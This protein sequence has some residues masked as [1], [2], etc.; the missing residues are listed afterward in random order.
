MLQGNM[1]HKEKR[2]HPTQKPIFVIKNLIE[3]FSEPKDII[4]DSF[5]GSGTTG[6]ACEK[7]G[8]RW[9]GIEIS[10]KYCEIAKKRIR[11]EANQH[12]LFF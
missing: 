3:R 4:L 5:L 1:K 11:A 10:E 8:R 7:L 9:I 2:Y 12:K 6:V